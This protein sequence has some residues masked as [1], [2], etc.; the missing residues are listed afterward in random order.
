MRGIRAK[1]KSSMIGMLLTIRGYCGKIIMTIDVYGGGMPFWQKPRILNRLR[2]GEGVNLMRVIVVIA[3]VAI[4]RNANCFR[5]PQ[6][7]I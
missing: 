2:P 1:E 5:K 6:R 3:V 7:N 4:E